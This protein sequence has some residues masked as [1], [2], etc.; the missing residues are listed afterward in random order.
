MPCNSTRRVAQ[1]LHG[2]DLHPFPM[3]NSSHCRDNTKECDEDKKPGKD[4][5]VGLPLVN[6]PLIPVIR[7]LIMDIHS[8]LNVFHLCFQRTSE[9]WDGST[10]YGIYHDGSKGIPR[11][12]LR[13]EKTIR[14]HGGGKID[15]S[16]IGVRREDLGIVFRII[17]MVGDITKT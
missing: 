6:F 8:Q 14:H 17:D 15:I 2:A 5:Y 3:N 11:N 9:I 12:S 7:R 1:R 16:I 13:R 4:S 10:F